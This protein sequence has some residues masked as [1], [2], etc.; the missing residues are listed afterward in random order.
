MREVA[1]CRDFPSD[2]NCSLVIAG[3]TEEVV[4]A[5]ALHAISVHG[6]ANSSELREQIRSFLKPA[7]VF[8][9]KL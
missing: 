3:E 6:H 7:H 1:D 8:S 2:I 4:D 9:D 5:A